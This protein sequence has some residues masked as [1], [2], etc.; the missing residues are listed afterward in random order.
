MDRIPQKIKTALP[1]ILSLFA[2]GIAGIFLLKAGW[3]IPRHSPIFGTILFLI[4]SA[5]I[6]GAIWGICY[7]KERELK[8]A[9]K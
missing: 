3:F 9:D 4:A 5:F 8:N 6:N 7:S 1:C 2:T